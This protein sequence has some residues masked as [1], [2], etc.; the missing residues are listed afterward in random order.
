VHHMFYRAVRSPN[1]SSIGHATMT[2]FTIAKPDPQP[3]LRS[4]L[5]EES[6]GIEDPRITKVEDTFYLLYTAWDGNSARIGCATSKNLTDWEKIGI[7]G[8][9]IAIKEAIDLTNSRFYRYKWNQ[10][11]NYHH[12]NS[13]LWD[14]DAIL[15]P[16]KI[17]GKFVMYHRFNPCIQVVMFDSFDQLR[18]EGFW[19]EYIRNVEEHTVAWPEYW[20]EGRKIGGGSTPI[21]T[22][23]GWLMFYHGRDV[24]KWYRAGVILFDLH[25]PTK[26]IGRLDEP[27][28]EPKFEWELTGVVNQ[29]VFPQGVARDKDTLH[30]YYGCADK[31]IGHTTVSLKKLL[32]MLKQ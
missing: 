17:D 20:W 12:E 19:R 5:P 25:D 18:D 32:K 10:Q 7:I 13:D 24:K 3:I 2:G 22:E 26:V 4:S 1:E 14:K 16:E 15:L 29:V 8:P 11:L 23:Q 9:K 6:V 30:I 28:F 27:L 31:R 21:R